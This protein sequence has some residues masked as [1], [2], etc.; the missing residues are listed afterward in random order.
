VFVYILNVYEA[1]TR[2]KTIDRPSE[3]P[4]FTSQNPRKYY[5]YIIFIFNKKVL[6]LKSFFIKISYRKRRFE[7]GY[8]KK[9][10]E[11]KIAEGTNAAKSFL[12][13]TT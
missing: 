9:L 13:N 5:M 2:E 4:Y 12:S 10:I 1:I 6:L 11:R 8:R 7:E 3:L